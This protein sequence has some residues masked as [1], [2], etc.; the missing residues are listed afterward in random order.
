MT[1]TDKKTRKTLTG[2]VVSDKMAKTLVV[3][4]DYTIRHPV[5]EKVMKRYRK[6]YVHDESNSHKVGDV[7]TIEETRPMSKLKRWQVVFSKA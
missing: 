4:V 1:V 2:T 6:Y 5:Y 7:V 3:S